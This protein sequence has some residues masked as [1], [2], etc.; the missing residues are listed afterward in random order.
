MKI[1]TYTYKCDG[2]GATSATADN[3]WTRHFGAYAGAPELRQ[4]NTF[5]PSIGGAVAVAI[6]LCAACSTKNTLAQIVAITTT[7]QPPAPV[8]PALP[9]KPA[10]S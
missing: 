9:V 3:T 5:P 1:T 2:C 8:R 10:G 7:K 6:D 4:Q